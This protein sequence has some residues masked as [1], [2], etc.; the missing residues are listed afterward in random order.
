[1]K[2]SLGFHWLPVD[3]I[4][5]FDEPGEFG[6][7]SD[8][9]AGSSHFQSLVFT[10]LN[11]SADE[12]LELIEVVEDRVAGKTSPETVMNGI[13]GSVYFFRG[14]VLAG[15]E[16]K[17]SSAVL[18]T[19]DNFLRVLRAIYDV[20]T[21]EDFRNP[22]VSFADVG[23]EIIAEGL[24]AWDEYEHRGGKYTR[25]KL[26]PKRC[27]MVYDGMPKDMKYPHPIPPHLLE[28]CE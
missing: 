10:D 1:M 28:L 6:I 3:D 22:D 14:D 27:E 25:W 19:S 11:D 7:K 13:D 21:S 20:F 18:L 2:R 8:G 5:V 4:C 23:Y 17:E 24:D 26:D 12:I 15:S 16:N 9:S